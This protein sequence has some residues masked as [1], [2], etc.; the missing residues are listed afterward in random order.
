MDLSTTRVEVTSDQ[1]SSELDGEEVILNLTD[2]TYY[3]LNE[4]GARIWAL[5]QETPALHR[6]RDQIVEEF[7]VGV[8]QCEHD[9]IALVKDL[10]EAGL[11]TVEQN[12]APTP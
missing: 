2:G 4:V 10:E 8:E 1:V 9:L 3:G 6:V 5:L 12:A 7:D 11:V